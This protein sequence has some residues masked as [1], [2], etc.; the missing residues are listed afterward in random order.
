MDA[1]EEE[2]ERGKK[3]PSRAEK[4]PACR[5]IQSATDT[6]HGLEDFL[7][8]VRDLVLTDRDVLERG[9]RAYTSYIRA[10]KEHRCAFIFR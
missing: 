9:T 5:K 6:A 4:N 3:I 7:P 2:S 1:D 10:Y 8:K